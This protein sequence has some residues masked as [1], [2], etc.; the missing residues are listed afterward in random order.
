VPKVV[1]MLKFH[2][3]IGALCDAIANGTGIDLFN[4]LH[5][6]RQAWDLLIQNTQNEKFPTKQIVTGTKCWNK[7]NK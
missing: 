2:Q 3:Q 7:N 5:T 1:D 4:R 6:G